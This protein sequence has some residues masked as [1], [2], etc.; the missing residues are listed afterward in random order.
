MLC[1]LKDSALLKFN[2]A[3]QK[4]SKCQY[5]IGSNIVTTFKV[6]AFVKEC[7]PNKLIKWELT[8]FFRGIPSRRIRE[9]LC[10]KYN[11]SQALIHHRYF[12]LSLSLSSYMFS[13]LLNVYLIL[14]AIPF[15]SILKVLAK[16]ISQ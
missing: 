16:S 1:I 10:F 7:D 8:K 6:S 5:L 14:T 11:L 9:L 13:P 2:G 3:A 12:F 15:P 4:N